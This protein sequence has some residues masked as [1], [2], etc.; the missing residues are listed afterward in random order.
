M[1]AAFNWHSPTQVALAFAL[2]TDSSGPHLT[3]DLK[4]MTMNKNYRTLAAL[5]VLALSSW[6]AQAQ[7]Q[8]IDGDG[9]NYPA[10]SSVHS[11]LTRAEVLA[12]LAAARANGTMPRYAE[13]SDVAYSDAA[14][15]G[16][17]SRADVRAEAIAASRADKT[18]YG[19]H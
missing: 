8:V 18:V 3:V 14:V 6:A 9:S 13:A 5:S 10:V 2:W 17:R 11:T 7:S 1:S 12:E 15:R 4:G 16:S 19:E